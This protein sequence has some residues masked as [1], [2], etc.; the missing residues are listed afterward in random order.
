MG[1]A[2]PTPRPSKVP[3]FRYSS[4]TRFRTS[5]WRAAQSTFLCPSGA[6]PGSR[7]SDSLCISL[8][9]PRVGARRHLFFGGLYLLAAAEHEA[10]DDY[11]DQEREK[12]QPYYRPARTPG[13]GSKSGGSQSLLVEAEPDGEA[14]DQA[15]QATDPHEQVSKPLKPGGGD[16]IGGHDLCPQESPPL[17]PR[18]EDEQQDRTEH[19]PRYG[20]VH[21]DN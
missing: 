15:A 17:H 19:Y 7:T 6:R 21:G 20:V 4:R 8:L 10:R 1:R 14:H 16:L 5:E 18:V 9:L 11:E 3:S 2:T 13:P 12:D